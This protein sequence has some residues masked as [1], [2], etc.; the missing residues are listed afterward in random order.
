MIII[1]GLPISSF[2]LKLKKQ[3]YETSSIFKMIIGLAIM[4]TGFIFMYFA[5]NESSQYGKSAMYWI[6]TKLK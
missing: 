4:G 3:G 6:N 5:S 2:W 1:F